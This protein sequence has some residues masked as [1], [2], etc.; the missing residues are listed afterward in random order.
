MLTDPE[1]V[2]LHD[3]IEISQPA[4]ANKLRG[5]H[6][7]IR[8]KAWEQISTGM[9]RTFWFS[10][11]RLVYRIVEAGWKA[12]VLPQPLGIVRRYSLDY[13]AGPASDWNEHVR[14]MATNQI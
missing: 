4:S 9:D 2:E 12:L 1:H 7:I 5:S 10:D 6:W 11:W 13:P 8:R 3:A 14:A